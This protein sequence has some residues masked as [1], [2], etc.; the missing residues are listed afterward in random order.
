MFG[1]K[2]NYHVGFLFYQPCVRKRMALGKLRAHAASV[3]L[4]SA[5]ILKAIFSSGYPF[6]K[7]AL[8]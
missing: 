3:C 2:R 1:F 6:S 4:S 7:S 5:Y 8:V